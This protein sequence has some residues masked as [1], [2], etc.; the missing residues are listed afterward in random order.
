MKRGR[1][2]WL[3]A[4]IEGIIVATVIFGQSPGQGRGVPAPA[5]H[6][7][8][9]ALYKTEEELMTALKAAVEKSPATA[10][11]TISV[12]DEYSV[13][14]LRRGSG[15]SALTHPGWT[16]VHYILEGSATFVT[17]GTLVPAGSP[18]AGR[19]GQPA[20]TIEGGVSRRVSKGDAVLVPAGTPHWYKSVDGAVTYLEVRF[21]A[22]TK[23]Q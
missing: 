5:P 6:A 9:P 21:I 4:A 7:G 10:T 15:A 18:A 23:A 16:E 11:S 8:S 19:Q 1:Q 2:P 14:I 17:G 20:Q 3:Y 22:P 12:T 13:N